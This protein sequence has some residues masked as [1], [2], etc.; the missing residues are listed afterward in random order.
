[1]IMFNQ[2][3]PDHYHQEL[4]ERHGDKLAILQSAARQAVEARLADDM[5]I[6]QWGN[7]ERYYRRAW[8]CKVS[9]DPLGELAITYTGGR[10]RDTETKTYPLDSVEGLGSLEYIEVAVLEEQVGENLPA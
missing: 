7:G 4:R 8:G 2:A 6:A 3:S 10:T 9:V 5:V 1:M